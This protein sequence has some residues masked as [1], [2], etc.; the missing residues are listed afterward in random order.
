[1]EGICNRCAFPVQGPEFADYSLGATP[2]MHAA[3]NGYVQCV[4]ELIAAGA[5]VNQA[6]NDG[7]VP[8]MWAAVE[9]QATCF[10]EL[11]RSGANVNLRNNDG[12]TALLCTAIYGHEE[13]IM[14]LTTAGTD[15]N[16]PD[17][18]GFTAL[19]HTAVKGH[20]SILQKL[21]ESGADVNQVNENKQTA[22][23]VA[24]LTGQKACMTGLINAGADVNMGDVNNATALHY[25]SLKGHDECL[26]ELLTTSDI[27]NT[28]L[29]GRTPLLLACRFGFPKCVDL[30]LKAGADV[31]M[32]GAANLTPL[33]QAVKH[34][35]DGCLDLLIQVGADVNKAEYT[36]RTPVASAA[37]Y[38]SR[39][40]LKKLLTAGA[41]VNLPGPLGRTALIE[42][43]WSSQKEWNQLIHDEELL[44]CTRY[45]KECVEMLIKSRADVNVQMP[46]H[47]GYTALMKASANGYHE[48]VQLL[49]EKGADVNVISTQSQTSLMYSAMFGHVACLNLLIGAGADVNTKDI[50]GS[51]ALFMASTFGHENCVKSL[52]EAGV[53]VNTKIDSLTALNEAAYSA[54]FKCIE[55]LLQ[56]GAD[57][58]GTMEG[59]RTA[60]L[61]A[62]TYSEH[63]CKDMMVMAGNVTHLAENHNVVKSIEALI[64]AGADVNIKDYAGN[65]PLRQVIIHGHEECVPLLLVAGANV[66]TIYY[67]S[68]RD[69]VMSPIDVG[70]SALM[71][72]IRL[73]KRGAFDQL[74]KAGADVNVVSNTGHTALTLAALEGNVYMAKHI[75][76]ANC[77]VNK[78]AGMTQNALTHHLKHMLPKFMDYDR[79]YPKCRRTKYKDISRL[80]FAAGEMLDDEELNEMLQDD[81]H[82]KDEKMQ[83]KHICREAIRNHLLDLYPHQH[84]FYRVPE[85]GLPEMIKEYLLYDESLDDDID[86]TDDD[87]NCDDEK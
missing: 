81:L 39:K 60:L 78:I 30:L 8:L 9:G 61:T 13:C 33:T 32:K 20:F 52:I 6:D 66:N 72:A 51:K 83:L 27:N 56:A 15:V 68:G 36:G 28:D 34:D 85:L 80:L 47:P 84:L 25:A 57:V 87:D 71:T 55:T 70:T 23:M 86:A 22:L 10:L 75:L 5:H 50:A 17:R 69:A 35:H 62:S 1:M 7:D 48:C 24:T 67:P 76:K 73:D 82:L 43:V 65:T 18:D 19:M 74:L 49:L 3:G 31:N 59:G 42:S 63:M 40:C 53:E 54:S 26:S 29:Y 77:R 44:H 45:P 4:K 11:I 58:N 46:G 21:L 12:Y 79:P 38:G 64:N 2:L 14:H 37:F 16:M 41:D